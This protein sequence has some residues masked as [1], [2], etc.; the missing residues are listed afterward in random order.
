MRK[1]A[2]IN[3]DASLVGVLSTLERAEGGQITSPN[4]SCVTWTS[5][6]KVCLLWCGIAESDPLFSNISPTISNRCQAAVRLAL[7]VDSLGRRSLAS[8]QRKKS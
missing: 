8:M 6:C 4:S 3:L 7:S 1:R 5:V 2:S